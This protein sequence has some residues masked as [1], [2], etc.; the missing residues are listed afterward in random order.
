MRRRNIIQLSGISAF[1]ETMMISTLSQGIDANSVLV[2]GIQF[3]LRNS[4][5]TTLYCLL[6][7]P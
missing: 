1:L 2:S 4:N 7:L 5:Y 3:K 6:A